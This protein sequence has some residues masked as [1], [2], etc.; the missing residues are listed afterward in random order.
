[1]HVIREV[2]LSCT[3]IGYN[4]SGQRKQNQPLPA[5]TRLVS[6]LPDISDLPE[7]RAG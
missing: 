4:G 3:G 1:M 5:T 6:Y 2:R 7:P